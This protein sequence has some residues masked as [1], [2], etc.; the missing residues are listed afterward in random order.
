MLKL[1][2]RVTDLDPLRVGVIGLSHGKSHV[3]VLAGKPAFRVTALVDPEPARR[4]AAAEVARC[5]VRPFAC[6]RDML[7]AECVDAVAIAV[8]TA[9]HADVAIECLRAGVHVLLEKPLCAID[10]DAVRLAEAARN[11]RGVFQLGYEVRSSPMHRSILRHIA[12]GDLGDVTNVWWNQH[13]NQNKHEYDG[14]RRSR[15]NMGGALLDCACH[16]LDLISQWARSP[17]VRVMAMGNLQ[18]HVGP[19]AADVLPETAVILLEYANGVRGTYNFGAVNQFRDDAT[20]GIAGTTGCIRGNPIS[21]GRFELRRDRGLEVSRVEFDPALTSA[22][23]L[24]FAEQWDAFAASIREG[25]ANV[26]PIDDALAIHTM[27]RAIDQSLSSGQVVQIEN[28]LAHVSASA[29]D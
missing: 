27:M 23:H 6:V 20:F 22:G 26:C 11:S 15:S 4:A 25:A 28:A 29:I 10:A 2:R 16:F 7:D 14:W 19:C 24:G 17:L 13:T 3:A 9:S 21:A 18:H 12:A 5:D 1:S 8:P